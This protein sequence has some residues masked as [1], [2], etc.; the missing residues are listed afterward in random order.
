MDGSVAPDTPLVPTLLAYIEVV[1]Q[2]KT[3]QSQ[4][5]PCCLLVKKTI[6]KDKCVLWGKKLPDRLA[7][8]KK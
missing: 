1:S 7:D 3:G 4:N 8:L 5:T 6:V 2:E